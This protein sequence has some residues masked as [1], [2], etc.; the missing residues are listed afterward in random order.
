MRLKNLLSKFAH[1]ISSLYGA[2]ATDGRTKA[3]KA[4]LDAEVSILPGTFEGAMA[5]QFTRD[6]RHT[7][8]SGVRRNTRG[9]PK[10]YGVHQ[11][12]RARLLSRSKKHRD[13]ASLHELNAAQMFLDDEKRN[14]QLRERTSA[15]RTPDAPTEGL[16]AGRGSRSFLKRV[17][18]RSHSKSL[19]VMQLI[20]RRK[21]ELAREAG[22]VPF[23]R[24]KKKPEMR[25]ARVERRPGGVTVVTP[26]LMPAAG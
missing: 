11:A 18:T 3:A 17:M 10:G 21:L 25:A 13:A 20:I 2:G 22:R 7:Q 5:A 23:V 4:R 6:V 15:R 8:K 1:A 16:L 19:R 24:P 26:S 9:L 12:N 14:R